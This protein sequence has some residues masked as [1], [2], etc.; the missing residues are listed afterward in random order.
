MVNMNS[1]CPRI[2]SAPVLANHNL[3]SVGKF[4]F[5]DIYVK[6]KMYIQNGGLLYRLLDVAICCISQTVVIFFFW[7]VTEHLRRPS[8]TALRTETA[9]PFYRDDIFYSGS[10]RRLSQYKSSVSFLLFVCKINVFF[11]LQYIVSSHGHIHLSASF[12]SLIQSLINFLCSS[13][14]AVQL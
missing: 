5:I 4:A 1:N 13:I 11:S 12:V 14:F 10:M 7:G 9:R 2:K 3:L 8:R 6:T